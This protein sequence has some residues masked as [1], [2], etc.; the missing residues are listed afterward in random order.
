MPEVQLALK[1]GERANHKYIMKVG[2]RY[3]YSMDEVKEFKKRN[4]TAKVSSEYRSMNKQK[5]IIGEINN[6]NNRL[7]KAISKKTVFNGQKMVEKARQNREVFTKTLQDIIREEK[8]LKIS[9]SKILTSRD[10]LNMKL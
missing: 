1:H 7:N 10:V 5:K 4:T 6:K 3:F 8:L 2:N 9:R